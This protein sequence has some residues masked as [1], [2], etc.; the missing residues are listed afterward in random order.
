MEWTSC[1]HRSAT[2]A[3]FLLI[4]SPRESGNMEPFLV[5]GSTLKWVY[6]QI[7]L[8][9]DKGLFK[10]WHGMYFQ[11]CPICKKRHH[12]KLFHLFSLLVVVSAQPGLSQS[13]RQSW[14]LP[15]YKVPY[16]A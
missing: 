16:N 4:T 1:V 11:R 10:G 5:S 3:T 14:Y 6:F 2:T 12:R 9:G 8:A 13:K 7:K 15:R